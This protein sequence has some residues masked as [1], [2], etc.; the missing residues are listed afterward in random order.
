MIDN[1]KDTDF[2]AYVMTY[3]TLAYGMY[4]MF[5]NDYLIERFSLWEITSNFENAIGLAVC[6]VA[7]VKIIGLITGNKHMKR[8]GIIGM[9]IVWAAIVGLYIFEAFN[10]QFLGLILTLSFLVLCLRIARRGTSLNEYREIIIGVFTLA[11][12]WYGKKLTGKKDNRSGEQKLID[13]LFNEI[14]RVDDDN[15]EIRLRLDNSEKE[16]LI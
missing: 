10:L 13:K 12:G 7:V 15:K 2:I 16:T 5:T 9:C 6:I 8:I 1:Q 4:L 3:A 14:E 11:I